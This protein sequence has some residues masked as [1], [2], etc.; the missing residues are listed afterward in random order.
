MRNR[1]LAVLLLSV[2][3]AGSGVV[4]TYVNPSYVCAVSSQ[5]LYFDNDITEITDED[6]T[7]ED[8]SIGFTV[9]DNRKYIYEY[10]GR[11]YASEYV[12][13]DADGEKVKFCYFTKSYATQEDAL[14]N[15]QAV[16]KDAYTN[17][18]LSELG[19]KSVS[20]IS[21]IKFYIY[22]DSTLEKSVT[23]DKID[24]VS[25][26]VEDDSSDSKDNNNN[27]DNSSNQEMNKKEGKVKV[28][29]DT[30]KLDKDMGAINNKVTVSWDI[31]NDRAYEFDIEGT[32]YMVD[33]GSSAKGKK[34]IT[35]SLSNGTYKYALKTNSG[36]DFTGSFKIKNQYIKNKGVSAK[37]MKKGYEPAPKLTLSKIPK[38]K[39]LGDSFDLT[40]TS[41]RKAMITFNGQASKG[42]VKKTK[43]SITSNGTYPYSAINESGE[44]TT[45]TIKVNCFKN[46]SYDRN[47]F[48]SGNTVGGKGSNVVQKL[49][50][51]GIYDMRMLVVAAFL[52][53]SGVVT[54]GYRFYKRRKGGSNAKNS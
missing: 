21:K 53:I 31:K 35:I 9:K 44:E 5:N 45:G 30:K 25:G 15:A 49:V 14:K 28:T 38:T 36:Q 39:Y 47:G 22:K 19:L 18:N 50:Q 4:G 26:I 54:L 10:N 16:P 27:S 12:V 3:L 33:I 37:K 29:V 46:Y 2:T 7:A 11:Y 34:T 24:S 20:D 1:A 48:W 51:T 13:Q 6:L 42:Y 41:D 8:V 43:Y 52:G 17:M 23:L 40:I 32:S